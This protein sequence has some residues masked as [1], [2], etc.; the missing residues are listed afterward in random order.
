MK[1]AATMSMRE[2]EA[3]CNKS[4]PIFLIGPGSTS[5]F[6]VR[7]RSLLNVVLHNYLYRTWFKPYRSEIEFGQFL[8][9]PISVGPDSKS[10]QLE[11][12]NGV[13]AAHFIAALS[14]K[15]CSR[16]EDI[17][18]K[19]GDRSSF[20]TPWDEMMALGKEIGIRTDWYTVHEQRFM[21]LQPLFRAVAILINQRHYGLDVPAIGHLP[22]L[23]VLTGYQEGLSAPITF[24]PIANRIR[25]Y[26]GAG[27]SVQ[28]VETSLATAIKFVMD[29]E[30]RELDAFGPRP[31]PALIRQPGMTGKGPNILGSDPDMD[32]LCLRE[33]WEGDKPEG[34][35]ST[36]VDTNIYPQWSGD[37]SRME[38]SLQRKERYCREILA[39]SI[40]G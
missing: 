9:Q 34:S 18:R 5:D 35:S 26:H 15:I 7:T 38:Y 36:W 33:G 30:K 4:V 32:Y 16:I 23:L 12:A 22:I 29:L 31:D 17:Q 21:V 11:F 25:A 13:D 20:T 8:A 6:N 3:C 37:G 28:A 27:D 14:H 40:A 19:I 10:P 24:E 39:K 2:M 1:K